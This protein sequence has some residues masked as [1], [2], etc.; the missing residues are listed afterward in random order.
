MISKKNCALLRLVSCDT[1][2]SVIVVGG[3]LYET[4]LSVAIILLMFDA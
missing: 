3:A 1:N 2:V 4:F